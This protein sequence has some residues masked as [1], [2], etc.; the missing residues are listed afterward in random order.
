MLHTVAL[1]VALC[2]L[3]LLATQQWH[4]SADIVVSVGAALACTA[5]ALRLGG[6]SGAFARSPKS[7]ILLIGRCGAALA[8]AVGTI[9]AALA[10]DVALSPAL[11]R[12]KTR[13]GPTAKA[14]LADLV[15]AVPGMVV[16][17]TDAEGLLAHVINEDAVE[18][19]DLSRLDLR[20]ANAFEAGR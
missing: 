14:L 19:A 6:A 16:V 20:V 15:S 18:G 12:V 4:T 17:E 1:F 3:W 7:M 13:V 5:F 9:R 8:G 11:V 2:V 10:A